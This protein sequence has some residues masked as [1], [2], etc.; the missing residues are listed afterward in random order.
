MDMIR[1]GWAEREGPEQ[2]AVNDHRVSC[3]FRRA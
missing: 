1:C 2:G 3:A